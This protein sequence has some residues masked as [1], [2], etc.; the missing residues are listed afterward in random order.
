MKWIGQHIVDF[1]A[2]FRSDVY[3]DALT[4]DSSTDILV[5]DSAGKICKNA[6]AGDDMTFDVAAD[7]GAD[8]SIVDGE[9]LTIAGG[10][11]I[12]TANTTNTVTI[13]HDDTSSQ[14]SSN[15]S[16]NTVI[17]DIAIDTY[18]HVTSLGTVSITAVDTA[19]LAEGAVLAESITVTAQ[20]TGDETVYPTFVDGAT[21]SQGLE[22]DTGLTYNPGTNILT[23]VN[24]AGA[25]AGNASG[26]SGSCTGN[27]ATST[28]IASITNTDIVQ[29]AGAQTLT[30][31]KTLNSFKGTGAT[32]VTDILDEDAMGSD[33]ATALATQQSI[34]AYADT[35]SLLAGSSSITT[36]GT[37][38]AGT[39]NATKI[40]SPKT[41][42]VIHYPF[43]GFCSGIA[44]GNFQY[45]AD[46]NNNKHLK[47]ITDYGDTV[48]ADGDTGD[49]QVPFRSS[50]IV[51][52][53]A[54]TAIDM[55]GWGSC[56][57]GEV[58]IALCKITPDRDA[59]AAEVPIVVA[60]TTFTGITNAK[61]ED[62]AVTDSGGGD[63]AVTIVT[64][65]IAKGDIL[66]PFVLT[67][68]GKTAYFN[69][70]LEVE[71]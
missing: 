17:Q 4:T 2:R 8:E 7:G 59:T 47:L 24:F 44:S 18:G 56:G 52:P 57:S 65:P 46:F 51:M 22:T 66:M 41:T 68:N 62:F 14:A 40:L 34:K 55:V 36:V 67:P 15:N 20:N 13:N 35:K 12:T 50:G 42:H 43:K 29:L 10:S 3:L 31:T 19:V 27:A 61:V 6:G 45:A 30:G 37:L 58:T 69:L 1:I 63:G 39:W 49:I 33:S 64:A 32:T 38:G 54:C 70:T 48:I 23:A 9:T 71:A 11:A 26:S 28:K 25:L 5:V 16:G 21:G 53:R 60:T